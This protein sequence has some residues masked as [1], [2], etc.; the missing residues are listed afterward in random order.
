MLLM[1]FYHSTDVI[2]DLDA[3]VFIVILEEVIVITY[4]IV[5]WNHVCLTWKSH[6]HSVICN[7]LVSDKG[8]HQ[9]RSAKSRT[10]VVRRTYSNYGDRCFAAAGQKLWNSLPAEL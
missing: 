9:L 2:S 3:T 10:C 5:N 7:K 4:S 8:R 6:I 1:R